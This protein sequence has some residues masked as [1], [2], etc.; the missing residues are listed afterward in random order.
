[1]AV[2]ESGGERE[3]ELE[4]GLRER[5]HDGILRVVPGDQVNL[6]HGGRGVIRTDQAEPLGAWSSGMSVMLVRESLVALSEVR[7]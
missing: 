3:R 6:G 7:G 4:T 2:E 1:M 5:G